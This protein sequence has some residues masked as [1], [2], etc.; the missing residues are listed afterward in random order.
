MNIK[1]ILAAVPVFA[2]IIG[3]MPMTVLADEN[4]PGIPEDTQEIADISDAEED[5]PDL[6]NVCKALYIYSVEADRYYG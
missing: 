6:K 1:K 5:D 3:S 4:D 2:M